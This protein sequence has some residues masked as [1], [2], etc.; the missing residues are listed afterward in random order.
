VVF[1]AWITTTWNAAHDVLTITGRFTDKPVRGQL[2]KIFSHHKMKAE[3]NE[4]AIY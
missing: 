3:L 2:M 4:Q 1:Y